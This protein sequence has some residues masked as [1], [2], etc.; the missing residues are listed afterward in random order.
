MVAGQ[1][2][3]CPRPGA[4]DLDDHPARAADHVGAA[5]AAQ[6]RAGQAG[7]GAQADQPGRAHPPRRRGLSVASAR[8]PA[9]SAGL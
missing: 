5:D 6:V 9:I 8:K 3:H 2:G 1:D 7:P 4:A